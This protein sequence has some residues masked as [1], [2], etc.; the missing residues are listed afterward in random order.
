MRQL[1]FLT[2]FTI[3]AGCAGKAPG[4][5]NPPDDPDSG[6]DTPPAA[7]GVRVSGK[8]MDYFT[9]VVLEASTV[10]T[11]GIDPQKTAT[12]VADG[13]YALDD[14]PIASSLYLSATHTNYRLTRNM[15]TTVADQPVL[16]DVYVLSIPDIQ[17]QYVTGGFGAPTA[18]QAFLAAE[19]KN[20][21]GAPLEGIP[22]ANITLLDDA[23]LPVIGT[24]GP[25]FFGANGDVDPALLTA[26]AFQGRSR[27]ALF[28]LPPGTYSLKVTYP[29]GAGIPK[30][31]LAP[32]TATAD[33]AVLAATGGMLA[34][35][36]NLDPTFAIDIY[37]R[38]QKAALGGLGCANCHTA[39]G[40]GA[41][42]PY[43]DLPATVLANMQA[44][45]GVL[46]LATP[47][48]SLLLTKP[49]YEPPPTPQNH[50]NATFLDI[51]DPDYKLFLR[52]ITNGAKP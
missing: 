4:D 34:G 19:L 5:Q 1:L 26:T 8:A 24:K 35:G 7:A 39:G 48:N 43:D 15:P 14:I 46:D 31:A 11:D 52:W 10:A 41:V 42:L 44:R 49:L 47:A 25:L 29:D 17:R 32:V 21:L 33:G 51:N 20:D 23:G 18:G 27:V 12:S 38:L 36:G 6:I 40:A 16:Q 9:A 28:D 2:T 50:P 45:L 22:L 13:T 3:L 37:P 30:D